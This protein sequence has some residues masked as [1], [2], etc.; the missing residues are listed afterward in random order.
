MRCIIFRPFRACLSGKTVTQAFAF[1]SACAD[2]LRPFR[3]GQ[4]MEIIAYTKL[5]LTIRCVAKRHS[6]NSLRLCAFARDCILIV[7]LASLP[8]THKPCSAGRL[9]ASRDATIYSRCL[10]YKINFNSQKRTHTRHSK[11][12]SAPFSAPLRLCARLHFNCISCLLGA[13]A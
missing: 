13:L 7:F 3:P 6:N 8:A 5:V 12:F 9:C 10:T 1:A 11:K 2:I 4:R